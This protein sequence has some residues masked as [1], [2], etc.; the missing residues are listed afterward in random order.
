MNGCDDVCADDA[1]K[2]RDVKVWKM[3]E[4]RGTYEG[5]IEGF[6]SFLRLLLLHGMA[7]AL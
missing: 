5:L 7:T 2:G 1:T 6:G 4:E 3:G